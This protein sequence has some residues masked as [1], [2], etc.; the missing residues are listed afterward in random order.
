ML[1]KKSQGSDQALVTKSVVNY[2]SIKMFHLQFDDPFLILNPKRPRLL[3]SVICVIVGVDQT[4][5]GFALLLYVMNLQ[6]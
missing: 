3:K 2:E 6:D 5:E 4:I 1:V